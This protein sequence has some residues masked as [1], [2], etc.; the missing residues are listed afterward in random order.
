[1]PNQPKTPQR[2]V[3][4]PDEVWDA[5][6]AKATK[7][8]DNLSDVIRRALQQYAGLNPDR[9]TP[10]RELREQRGL[11]VD[12]MALLAECDKATISRIETGR[13]RAGVEVVVRL[14]KVLGISARRMR[15]LCDAGLP[16]P[17]AP[18]V[19]DDAGL[20]GAAERAGV[21]LGGEQ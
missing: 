10:L 14:A 16:Q 18:D 12:A 3:R 19:R 13:S 6:K 15:T 5:A 4:V 17:P 11:T 1:M 8:G 9:T 20:T 2:T 7:R 21:P